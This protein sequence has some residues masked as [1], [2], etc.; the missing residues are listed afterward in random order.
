MHVLSSWCQLDC[1]VQLGTTSS[2]SEAPPLHGLPAG[3]YVYLAAVMI[4]LTHPHTLRST[5]AS[6]PGVAAL[7]LS[8]SSY[9]TPSALLAE[10]GASFS[11]WTLCRVRPAQRHW[12]KQG[13]GSQVCAAGRG[14]QAGPLQWTH[15]LGSQVCDAAAPG[16]TALRW[17]PVT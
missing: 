5:L 4:P 9:V 7:L 14:K 12:M 10:A 16:C 11:R 8:L 1:G 3:P 6:S 15:Q 13:T 17:S 2:S